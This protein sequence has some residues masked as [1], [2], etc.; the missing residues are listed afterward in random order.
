MTFVRSLHAFLMNNTNRENNQI[1]RCQ[2]IFLF[3]VRQ[4]SKEFASQVR[5]NV[6]HEE[7][8]QLDK[9]NRV[10]QDEMFNW[11]QKQ[12]AATEKDFAHCL[13]QIGEAHAAAEREN[14]KQQKIDEQREKNRR[15][16]LKR[17]KI[18]V[19]KLKIESKMKQTKSVSSVKGNKVID[20]S[21][22][23]PV[24]PNSSSSS[25][26]STTSPSSS[27]DSSVVSVI[28]KKKKPDTKV[29][30]VPVSTK[31][32]NVSS[33]SK[34]TSKVKSPIKILEYNPKRYASAN[35]SPATDMSLT[36][37]TIDEAPPFITKVSDLLGRKPTKPALRSSPYIAKTYKL[38]KSPVKVR[39]TPKK[40]TSKTQINTVSTRLSRAIQTPTKISG[41]SPMKTLPERKHFVPEFVKGKPPMQMKKDLG[42]QTTPQITSKIRFYDH[43]N[44]FSRH[45]NGSI[46]VEERIL[47]TLPL[48]AWEE[49][50][51]DTALDGFKETEQ[52]HLRLVFTILYRV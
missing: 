31:I 28:Q 43:A 7:Q 10:M 24:S 19:E 30:I 51:K 15:M 8:R 5:E 6:Q 22:K 34:S 16:A 27:S 42:V 49:A 33:K 38:D 2:L 14:V 50:K 3:Q 52:F 35:S 36:D 1:G 9:I 12:I 46:D 20:H 37:S 11:R 4:Q 47:N 23:V 39:N 25:S 26:S 17:G 29:K 40:S 21:K 45:Y 41:K 18:A 44:K 32:I 48:N 13:D